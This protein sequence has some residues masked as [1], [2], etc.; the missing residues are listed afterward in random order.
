MPNNTYAV[1]DI[2]TNTFRLLIAKIHYDHVR[3]N[4]DTSQ[5]E[6][7]LP[8]IRELCSERII[9]RLGDGIT[10]DGL[11]SDSSMQKGLDV[12]KTF[13]R[14]IS[15]NNVN[16]TYAVATSA[17]R[18]AKNSEDFIIKARIQSGLDVH[19]ISGDDE[20]RLTA[21]GMI[22][23]MDVPDTVIMIDIGG[24]STELIYSKSGIPVHMQSLH[25][26]AVYLAARYMKTDPPTVEMIDEMEKEID[27]VITAETAIFDQM[28]DNEVCLIG[29]AGTI[30]TLAAVSLKLR[31]FKHDI[32]HKTK[33]SSKEVRNIFSRIALISSADR[34]QYIPFEPERLDII[35]PGT[36]IL[37]KLMEHFQSDEIIV[38]NNGLREG[39]ILELFKS[40][41]KER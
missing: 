33:L 16:K 31:S 36:L 37:L 7:S 17:L 24:G 11:I 22:L 13:N 8:V 3:S 18:E 4:R 23:D 29:T 30:T 35:V 41:V 5:K 28:A 20:A 2:G 25:L 40:G 1:I 10:A 9:T 21:A 15:E 6:V 38:S 12:L 19:T 39:I 26:G 14:I 27:K 32:I 34:S